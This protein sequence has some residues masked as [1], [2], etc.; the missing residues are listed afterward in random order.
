MK[1]ERILD[2]LRILIKKVGDIRENNLCAKEK[3]IL[4]IL[5]YIFVD[6]TSGEEEDQ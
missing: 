5:I 6:H 3:R 1:M 2:R 4:V